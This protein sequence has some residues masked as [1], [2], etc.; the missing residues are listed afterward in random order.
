MCPQLVERQLVGAAEALALA[1]STSALRRTMGRRRLVLR[2]LRHGREQLAAVDA[3][4][5]QVIKHL[6]RKHDNRD[7]FYLFLLYVLPCGSSRALVC[8]KCYRIRRISEKVPLVPFCRLP[9][10]KERPKD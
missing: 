1:L 5:M 7:T 4:L 10:K 9:L 2:Q 3:V 8:E 6:Q